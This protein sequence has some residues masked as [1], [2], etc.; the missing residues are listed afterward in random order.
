MKNKIEKIFI[1]IPLKN[2]A[3]TI[4]FCLESVFNQTLFL[5]R[6][7]IQK[8]LILVHNNHTDDTFEKCI[9]YLKSNATFNYVNLHEN[10]KGIT[11]TLNKGLV[12]IQNSNFPNSWIARLDGDDVWQATKLQKQI[13]FLEKSESNIDIVGT[14][15][16]LIFNNSKVGTITHPETHLEIVEKFKIA[17]NAIAHPTVIFNS[18]ILRHLGGYDNIFPLA[19][20]MWFWIRAILCD[21][22]LAN[23]NECLVDYNWTPPKDGYSPLNPQLQ[24]NIFKLIEGKLKC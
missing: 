13:D 18:K 12:Y 8:E 24:A 20:D 19:E 9:S 2:C 23:I 1:L 4:E 16:N 3:K 7:D 5:K 22:K 21:Y 10:E 17:D 15:M 6:K 14:G 11:P